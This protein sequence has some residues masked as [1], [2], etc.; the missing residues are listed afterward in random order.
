MPGAGCVQ[1]SCIFFKFIILFTT[2]KHLPH[3]IHITEGT[4]I[5]ME[6]A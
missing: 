1:V 6:N 4:L 5:I 2:K 3:N